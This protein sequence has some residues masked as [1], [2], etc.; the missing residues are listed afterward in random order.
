MP[1]PSCAVPLAPFVT[2]ADALGSPHER[3]PERRTW[4]GGIANERFEAA[5]RLRREAKQPEQ[6]VLSLRGARG[7]IEV[8][9]VE[10]A[11]SGGGNRWP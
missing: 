1:K 8:T 6:P 3:P 11:R 7:E 5:V 4:F 2:K 9:G 10:R